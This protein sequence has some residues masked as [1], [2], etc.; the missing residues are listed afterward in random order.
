MQR[1]STKQ[2]ILLQWKDSTYQFYVAVKGRDSAGFRV[3]RGAP[4]LLCAPV[5]EAGQPAGF[6]PAPPS[7]C[8]DVLTQV[9]SFSPRIPLSEILY[10]QYLRERRDE[11]NEF[12]EIRRSQ[13]TRFLTFRRVRRYLE[14]CSPRMWQ[15]VSEFTSSLWDWLPARGPRHGRG[16]S[17][18]HL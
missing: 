6:L 9:S 12:P 13:G 2:T 3:L 8:W 16:E 15:R 4:G 14:K 18:T 11:K 1:L 7:S 10:L 17:D 5:R